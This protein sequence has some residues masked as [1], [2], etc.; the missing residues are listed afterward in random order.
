MPA[1]NRTD[2]LLLQAF[3]DKIAARGA[4]GIMGIGR[5]FRIFDDDGSKSLCAP[6]FKKAI[7][8]F[9]VGL[10]D[11]EIERLFKIFDTN[12]GGSID[13]EEF[14]LGVRGEMNDFRTAIALKAF[15]VMDKDGSGVLD[16]SDIRGTYNAKKHPDVI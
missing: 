2:A 12:Q 5:L 4:R 3:R 11:R 13:Y 1:V 8:D 7:N 14:L 15:K 9:R 10:T 6:E 16:I